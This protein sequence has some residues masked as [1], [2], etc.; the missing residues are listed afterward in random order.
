[1]KIKKTWPLLVLLVLYFGT[2]GARPLFVPDEPRYAQIAR[3]MRQTGEYAAPR[4]LGLCYYEK[5]VLGHWMNAG[6][7]ALFGENVFSI[8]FSSAL[9][10]LLTG[11]LVYLLALRG[12][13][14]SREERADFALAAA[15]IFY[16]S[17][18]VFAIGT[19][20]VLDAPFSLFVAGSM[21]AFFYGATEPE[22]KR[23]FLYLALA[24]ISCGLAFLTKGFI[25]LALPSLTATAYLLWQ[26]EPKRLLTL[27]WIPLVFCAATALP[28]ALWVHR[29]DPD[30]WHYFFWV[31]HIQRAVG[32]DNRQ[33]PEG[34]WYFIPILLAGSLPWLFLIEPIRRGFRKADWEHPV[35]RFCAALAV[36]V[37][38]FFSIPRGKLGTYILPM[39]PAVAVL[40]AWGLCAA[41]REG[42]KAARIFDRTLRV[43]VWVLAPLALGFFIWQ[44]LGHFNVLPARMMLYG[45]REN[46]VVPVVALL[47][48]LGLWRLSAEEKEAKQKI[49]LF[50]LGCAAAM[51]SVHISMPKR[52]TEHLAPEA[53]IRQTVLPRMTV[54][55]VVLMADKDLAV[56]TAWALNTTDLCIYDRPGEHEYG[57]SRLEDAP[58][59]VTPAMLLELIAMKKPIVLVSDSERRVRAMPDPKTL[60]RHRSGRCFVVVF[61]MEPGI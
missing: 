58:R 34:F 39:F 8:R 33:H 16:T 4:L 30:F 11:V 44:V 38:V 27:P 29:V 25:A 32:S 7:Q 31:E 37:F 56:A 60:Y 57:L 48:L 9:S 28:W 21:T 35:L 45:R 46:W 50:A 15:T 23:R 18:L 59:Q 53:F 10:T 22:W 1:M 54:P 36:V 43:V 52:F 26:R 14:G 51:L 19:Y 24:G 6:S 17:A 5:P 40:M 61:N 3:E 2:I 41:L 49:M 42:G 47:I 13:R 55:D 12:G 20:A